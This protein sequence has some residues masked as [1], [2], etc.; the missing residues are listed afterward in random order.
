EVLPL[1]ASGALSWR[2]GA[3][4]GDVDPFAVVDDALER[5]FLQHAREL[6]LELTRRRL[7][8]ALEQA[9][10]SVE[11]IV[12]ALEARAAGEALEQALA[13]ATT[14]LGKLSEDLHEGLLGLDELLAREAMA[15]GL[16]DPGEGVRR[17]VD[18]QDG[19]Y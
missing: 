19:E 17:K 10:A 13:R 12:V 2:T 1:S 11:A 6:K 4:T 9:K 8:E 5:W 3:Q 18:E 7:R 15:I 16:V 14:A